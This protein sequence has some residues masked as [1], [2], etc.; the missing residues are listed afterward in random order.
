MNYAVISGKRPETIGTSCPATNPYRSS[1][2]LLTIVVTWQQLQVQCHHGIS[3][4]VAPPG[5]C[6]GPELTFSAAH[7]P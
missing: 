7:A 6:H 5:P 4:C 1:G 2:A 3:V